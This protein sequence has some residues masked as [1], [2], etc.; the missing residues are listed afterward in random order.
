MAEDLIVLLNH[1]GWTLE[2]QLHIIGISL[3]GMITLGSLAFLHLVI[4]VLEGSLCS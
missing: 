2:R 3:G 4:V 1:I